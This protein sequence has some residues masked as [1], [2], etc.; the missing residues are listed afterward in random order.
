MAV[1]DVYV[2]PQIE[3]GRKNRSALVMGDK[4]INAIQTFEVAAGDDDL[5]VYRV[6]AGVP[7]NLIPTE[8]TICCDA[9]TGGTDWDL[10]IYQVGGGVIDKD[11][12]MDGQ[13]MASALTRATGHQLGLSAVNIADAEKTLAQLSGQANPDP[14]YDIVLTANVA[15]TAAGTITVIA[16]F[17]QG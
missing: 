4:D 10:G 7:S 6:F 12:L 8:I 17:T 9:I 3:A 11:L 13:T 15:G 1:V 2:D 14:A 5:S 16:T